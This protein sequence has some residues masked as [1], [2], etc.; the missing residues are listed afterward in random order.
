[1]GRPG[2]QRCALDGGTLGSARCLRGVTQPPALHAAGAR[3]APS[4]LTPTPFLPLPSA[5]PSSP[6]LSLIPSKS[7]KHYTL[8]THTYT[9]T[10][11]SG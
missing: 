9:H 3:P 7:L 8:H 2:L 1:M 4:S 6:L 5:V 10:R 11:T